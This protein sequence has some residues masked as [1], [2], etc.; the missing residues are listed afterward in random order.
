MIQDQ[1]F[2]I[3]VKGLDEKIQELQKDIA[4][5]KFADLYEVGILQGHVAGLEQSRQLLLQAIDQSN[6]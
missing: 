6:N 1:V 5:A 4:T 2:A 3:Y